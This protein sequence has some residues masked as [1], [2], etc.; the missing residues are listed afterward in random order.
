MSK[1]KNIQEEILYPM[2]WFFY[3]SYYIR[4]TYIITFNKFIIFM[5][6]Y[7]YRVP[8]RSIW[9]IWALRKNFH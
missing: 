8:R 9:I 1:I 6:T 2:G 4:K 3:K 5:L 7:T